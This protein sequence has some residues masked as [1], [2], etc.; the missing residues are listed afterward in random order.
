MEDVTFAPG[1]TVSVWPRED[2]AGG[3]VR[4]TEPGLQPWNATLKEFVYTEHR[5]RRKL[6]ARLD[7]GSDDPRY[8]E[9]L[10][11]PELLRPAR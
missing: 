7:T 1:S 9:R 11:D 4:D 2:R 6:M 5:G 8:R 10:V 3:M